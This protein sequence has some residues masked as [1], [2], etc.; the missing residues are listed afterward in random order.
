MKPAD[1]HTAMA[2]FDAA[3]MTYCKEMQDED[4]KKW[5]KELLL[6]GYPVV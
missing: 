1:L 2:V 5:L 4:I 3:V 6:E